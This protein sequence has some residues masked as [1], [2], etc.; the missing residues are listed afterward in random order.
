MKEEISYRDAGV[1]IDAAND[2]TARIRRLARETFTAGVMTDI[3]SFGGMFKADFAGMR[4]PVLVS[5]ADGVGHEAPRSL[6]YGHS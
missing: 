2:A 4:D 6:S 5:S 3:G 1:D